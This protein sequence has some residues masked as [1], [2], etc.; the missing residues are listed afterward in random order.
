MYDPELGLAMPE[1][2][3]AEIASSIVNDVP[4]AI[5]WLKHSF[6]YI[7]QGAPQQ[8]SPRPPRALS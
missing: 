8:R 3:N 5:E 7:R 6:F 2:L 1:H 4:T